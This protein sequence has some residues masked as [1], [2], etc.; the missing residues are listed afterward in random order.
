MDSFWFSTYIVIPSTRNECFVFS[1]PVFL[2][3]ISFSHFISLD[4]TRL[5]GSKESI[6]KISSLIMM[7]AGGVYRHLYEIKEVRFQS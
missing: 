6:I 7:L 5:N 1:F 4:S 3:T 2:S